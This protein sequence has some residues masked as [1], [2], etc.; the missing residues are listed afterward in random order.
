VSNA[1]KR[2]GDGEIGTEP[3]SICRGQI[4]QRGMNINQILLFKCK[5]QVRFSPSYPPVANKQPD[6]TIGEIWTKVNKYATPQSSCC[7]KN[8]LP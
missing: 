6:L 1:S 8:K 7:A 2:K 3:F 5:L 4:V